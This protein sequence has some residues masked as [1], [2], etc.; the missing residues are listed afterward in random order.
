MFALAFGAVALI[1]IG[2]H[3]LGG[4]RK[5]LITAPRMDTPP[6]PLDDSLEW[7][8]GRAIYENRCPDCGAVEN[9]YQ[10]PQ[11]KLRVELY[12]ANP[13]CRHGFLV[14]NYGDGKV[15]AVRSYNGPNHLY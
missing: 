15:W 9:F 14:S 11:H 1:A 12:C 13:K 5:G 2:G 10:G 4:K 3:L 8:L 7:K 6:P